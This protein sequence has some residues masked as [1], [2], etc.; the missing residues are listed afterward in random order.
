MELIALPRWRRIDFISDLHLQVDQTQTFQAWQNYLLKTPADAVFILGDL[1]EVW[2]GD[3]VLQSDSPFEHQCAR[4]LREAAARLDIYIMRGNRDFLMGAELMETCH[5][6]LLSDPTTLTFG[7]ERWLLTHGDAWCL[8]DQD[9]MRF[10]AMVRSSTWQA[11]FLAQ[12]VTVRM[13]LAQHMRAQSEARKHSTD[14]Y[15]DVDTAEAFSA[16]QATNARHLIH[17]HT[18]RPATHTVEGGLERIVLS[19][20]D[21]E[22]HPPRAEV[23]RLT[24]DGA[25]PTPGVRVQRIP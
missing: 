7:S 11:D 20:W 10:R 9:Y 19:D 1:F 16:L 23:L 24:L 13:K 8:D 22:A 3:D 5:C 12:P 21:L 2:I 15:A 17:G 25:H 6:T 14:T 18:H 4:T